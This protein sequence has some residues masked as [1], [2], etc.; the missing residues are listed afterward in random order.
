MDP[1][2]IISVIAGVI[3]VAVDLGPS[4]IKLEQDAAPFAEAIYNT[5]KG[6]AITQ[7]QLDTLEAKITDLSNQL[8]LTLPLDDGTTTT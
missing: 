8:Q 2:T 1:T 6:T 7:E 4:I 3:K 5:F